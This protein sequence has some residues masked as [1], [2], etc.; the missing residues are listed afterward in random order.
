[1]KKRFACIAFA[2][3]LCAVSILPAFAYPA[4]IDASL[5]RVVDNGGLLSQSE[6]ARLEQRIDA[7]VDEYHT[8]SSLSA[9][10]ASATKSPTCT[11][12]ITSITAATAG[13]RTPPMTSPPAAA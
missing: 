2:L 4:G 10:R 11:P 12:P 8:E 9:R 7:L 3:L 13:A 6:I 1:M 5:P